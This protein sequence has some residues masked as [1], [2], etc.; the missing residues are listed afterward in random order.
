[1]TQMIVGQTELF[2]AQQIEV[3]PWKWIAVVEWFVARVRHPYPLPQAAG[4][5]ASFITYG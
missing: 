3:H 2:A 1:M 5:T 4:P